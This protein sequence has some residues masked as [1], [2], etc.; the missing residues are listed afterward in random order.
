MRYCAATFLRIFSLWNCQNCFELSL[1][2]ALRRTFLPPARVRE[3]SR[4]AASGTR[5]GR[6]GEGD[7]P[8]CSSRNSVT[9]YT[10]PSTMTQAESAVA[11]SD[12]SLAVRVCGRGE[13]EVSDGHSGASHML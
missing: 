9:S 3:G 11:W 5:R 12:T 2:H 8:G 13:G 7:A 6:C 1:P 4:S 10:P